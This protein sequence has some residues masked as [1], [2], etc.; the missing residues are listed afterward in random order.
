MLFY[1]VVFVRLSYE[2]VTMTLAGMTPCVP[3][4]ALFFYLLFRRSATKDF[5]QTRIFVASEVFLEVQL[6]PAVQHF[7]Q[8]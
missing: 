7:Q 1:A 3:L 5:R 2:G 4:P 8:L 6:V